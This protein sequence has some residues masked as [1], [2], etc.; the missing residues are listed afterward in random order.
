MVDQF[1]LNTEPFFSKIKCYHSWVRFR[2]SMKGSH[3]NILLSNMYCYQREGEVDREH[4]LFSPHCPP[5]KERASTLWKTVY[6]ELQLTT[7]T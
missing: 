4:L 5:P 7:G 1:Y 3:P 2:P 6:K